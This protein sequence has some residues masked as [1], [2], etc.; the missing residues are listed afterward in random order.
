MS[1]IL[2]SEGVED[3]IAPKDKVKKPENKE[4]TIEGKVGLSLSACVRDIIKGNIKEQDVA[5][6]LSGTAAETPE[7]WDELIDSYK[8]E[9]WS[10]D[11]DQAEEVVHRLLDQGRI[12]QPR[13]QERGED[14]PLIDGVWVSPD[15]V[16]KLDQRVIDAVVDQAKEVEVLNQLLEWEQN[17]MQTEMN[18]FIVTRKQ[19]IEDAIPEKDPFDRGRMV[20][21]K[22]RRWEK[23]K[24]EHDVQS[25]LINRKEQLR[26]QFERELKEKE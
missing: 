23:N 7:D 17:E 9:Q 8:K 5:Q 19:E 6:I 4:I 24:K 18:Q 20:T 14:F 16:A 2:K 15:E 13:L 12:Q 22:L 21:N 11:P 25:W 26:K 10:D 1:E 3:F